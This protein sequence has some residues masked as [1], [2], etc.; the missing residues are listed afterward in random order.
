MPIRFC[1]RVTIVV[2]AL[3]LS[4]CAV[5]N[6]PRTVTVPAEKLQVLLDQRFPRDIRYMELFDLHLSNPKLILLPDSN[7]VATTMDVVIA[8][9]FIK[10]T[11]QGTVTL[12]G[13]LQLNALRHAVVIDAAHLDAFNIEGFD[14]KMSRQITQY[15]G[16][17]AERILRDVPIVTYGEMHLHPGDSDLV[18]TKIGMSPNGL[19]V[20]FEPAQ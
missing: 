15:G 13:T 1:H 4:A 2:A 5:F 11:W 20:T 7:R 16:L 18:P 14:Q 9:P 17:L 12:S 10:R 19:M 3:V 6:G 8:P